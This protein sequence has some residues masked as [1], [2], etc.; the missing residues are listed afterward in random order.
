MS[1]S[2]RVSSFFYCTAAFFLVDFVNM[3]VFCREPD[4]VGTAHATRLLTWCI[5]KL[6]VAVQNAVNMFYKYVAQTNLQLLHITIMYFYDCIDFVCCCWWWWEQTACILDF[7]FS[8]LKTYAYIKYLVNHHGHL[9]ECKHRE[10]F[11]Y[12]GSFSCRLTPNYFWVI[13]HNVKN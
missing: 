8:K 1:N 5:V 13:V 9:T 6:E 10:I 7:Q 4:L 12:D 11:G 2:F 3:Y